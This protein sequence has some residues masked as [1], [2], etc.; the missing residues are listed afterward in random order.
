MRFLSFLESLIVIAI[1]ARGNA[2]TV[3]PLLSS[4]NMVGDGIA[5]ME[6]VPLNWTLS[7]TPPYEIDTSGSLNLLKR[8][9]V[10]DSDVISL[11][12][13]L[14]DTLPDNQTESA[15]QQL[16][17]LTDDTTGTTG[18]DLKMRTEW[19]GGLSWVDDVEAIGSLHASIKEIGWSG[20][21]DVL[22]AMSYVAALGTSMA[23]T[24]A[25]YIL[26]LS[27][28]MSCDCSFVLIDKY[29]YNICSH[30]TGSKCNT[31]ASKNM[32]AEAQHRCLID[33]ANRSDVAWCTRIDNSG[34]WYAVVKVIHS[35]Y[36]GQGAGCIDWSALYC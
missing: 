26:G 30:T 10:M 5:D 8:D 6:Y 27:Q 11:L 20:T 3:I 24:V 31:L 19:C 14:L 13:N 2:I 4:V 29:M 32:I 16:I 22:E 18:I 9:D 28:S 35:K 36:V 1:I 25:A 33:A 21:K 15:R 17:T 7:D 23:Q 34:S 12:Y